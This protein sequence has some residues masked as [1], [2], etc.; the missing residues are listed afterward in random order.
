M[1]LG[2]GGLS[3]ETHTFLPEKTTVEPF[4]EDAVRGE[5]ALA[6]YRGTN[7]VL[8][9][10][11]D[12]CEDTGHELVPTV[13]AHGGVSG[14]VVDE[15][16]DRFV[17]EMVEGFEPVADELDGVLLFL[18]GA[19][20]TE[21][22]LDPET[23]VVRDVRDVVGD[24]PIMVGMDLHGNIAPEMVDVADA[25]CP[26]RSSPHV[27]QQETG[28]RTA[29]LMFRTVE[30][31]VSPT[32]A[33]SKPGLAIPS[34]FS[35]T[36]VSPARDVVSRSISWQVQ[37]ELYDVTKWDRR[38]DVLDVS[39]FFGF[40]WSDV[41]QVGL[42]AIAVT[43]DDAELAQ[44]IADDVA[45]FAWDRRVEFTDPDSLYSVE[46][47]VSRAVERAGRADRPVLLLDHADRLSETTYVLRELLEQGATNV[48][49]PLLWDPE[50]VEECA[51]AGQ[52]AEVTLSVGSKTSPRGGGPVDVTGT[53]EWVGENPYISTGPM[54]GGQRVDNGLTAILDVD[55]VWVQLT[56]N[57]NTEMVDTD[58]I[59]QYG[60]DAASFDIIVSKSKT[61]FRAVYE[62]FASEIIVA[63]APEYSP[64]DLATFDY[65]HVEDV[66]P[67]T[68]TDE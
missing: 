61:H 64:A 43:D 14:T 67:I 40:A 39:C 29:R 24:V 53:V 25:I 7:T 19:M 28:R 57:M 59:E 49:Y 38:D 17:G 4:E 13:Y 10:F 33:I 58:P 36:T 1:K 42:S 6:A 18:H 47:A 21:S 3:H 46:E 66:Y 37:P 41:P 34:P 16:Y 52:G 32:T 48:A 51:A 9:G 56:E 60:Y 45:D 11:V 62:D 26:Y 31:D 5:D 23:D 55:G 12:A 63:D 68:P 8:G 2:V 30:G 65:Q 27:D 22:R 54:L 20:V 35:A 15:A 44:E 50:A